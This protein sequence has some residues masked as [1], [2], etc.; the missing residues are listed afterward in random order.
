MQPEGH[1]SF[2]LSPISAK[3]RLP[4][5]WLQEQGRV[6]VFPGTHKYPLGACCGQSL[7]LSS[8]EDWSIP[9]KPAFLVNNPSSQPRPHRPLTHMLHTVGVLCRCWM[10][11]SFNTSSLSTT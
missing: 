4:F 8:R 7:G 3:L 5:T 1:P 10:V 6:S 9:K 2:L 11:H